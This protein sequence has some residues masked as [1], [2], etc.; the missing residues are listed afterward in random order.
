M[1]R[2]HIYVIYTLIGLLGLWVLA[3]KSQSAQPSMILTQSGDTTFINFPDS[4]KV[5]T[6]D[7]PKDLKFAGERVPLEQP[8][9][10]ERFEREI[11]VNTYWNS[12]TILTIKRAGIWLPQMEKILEKNGVPTDFKYLA[13]IES[14]LLNVV[15]PAR[16]TGFWQIL[17]KTGEEL[18]LEI[19]DEIDQ[20]Y[21]PIASTEAAC[22]YLLSAYERFGSWTDVAASY[23]MGRT[24]LLRRMDEQKVDSYYD[25]LLNEETSR[26]VF[27]ILA[28][29]EIFEK[30]KT[31]GYE[32]NGIYQPIEL[33]EVE[34]TQSIKDLAVFAQEQGINYK[35]LK[36]Y[37]PWLRKPQL[38]VRKGKSY[39]IHIPVSY[40]GKSPA[41]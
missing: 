38:T 7:V 24:G 1:S 28:M 13:V 10:L 23:N 25:L 33:R 37:N 21:D 9:V 11:Y 18:G 5:Y 29:K 16:A 22:K 27:R 4:Y 32:I 30:P 20:R 3:S 39:T 19:N 2:V 41:L 36:L 40:G 35:I 15:S 17:P 6:F 12:N 8:D 34:V 31:Y 26:Y 14:G